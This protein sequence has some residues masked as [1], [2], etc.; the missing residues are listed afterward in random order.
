[1]DDDV[2]KAW[3]NFL[4]PDILRSNLTVASLY[5]TAFEIL[6]ASIIDKIKD[7]YAIGFDQN[8]YVINEKYEIEVLSKNKSPLYAS[9]SWLKEMSAIDDS[10]LEIFESI[11]NKRNKLA[12]EMPSL[13]QTQAI[14]DISDN[15]RS[16]IELLHKIGVWW[17]REV[18]I[19]TD[20]DFDN[21]EV[22]SKEIMSGS[23]IM[24][25]LMLD[26]AL[27]SEEESEFYFKEFIKKSE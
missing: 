4:N 27:G 5:I 9:L 17:V 11:K 6:K 12:H 13:L 14:L 26:I 8:D 25:Q 10:D 15:F 22:D 7:F 16:L 21:L 18:E 3:E 2:K 24:L 23:T 20:P 1:M 19:P